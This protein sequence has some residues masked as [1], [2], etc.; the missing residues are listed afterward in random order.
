MSPGAKTKK[1]FEVRREQPINY[2]ERLF[3]RVL[4]D[5]TARDPDHIVALTPKSDTTLPLSFTSITSSQPA[6]AV[7]F[8]SYLLDKH[9]TN[10]S[11]ETNATIAFIS[12]QDFR[13]AVM[14]LSSMKTFHP[15]LLP[16]SRNVLPNTASLIKDTSTKIL[17]CSGARTPL[18]TQAQA[19]QSL[20][21]GL[22]TYELPI[23]EEMT[24]TKT[25]HYPYTA[26][27]F[28]INHQ[29]AIIVYIFGLIGDPKL[30]AYTYAYLSRVDCEMLIPVPEG[31]IVGSL[32]LQREN[33]MN[34]FGG[35]FFHLSGVCIVCHAIFGNVSYVMGPVDRPLTGKIAYEIERSVEIRNILAS[36]EVID[37][38][39]GE[40]GR[41]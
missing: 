24:T 30:I 27:Y 20:I 34:F 36:P 2:G 12:L 32:R 9:L 26:L 15:L 14:E 41:S 35:R 23:L 10:N 39:F 1:P 7:N 17:F 19:F 21:S 25:K 3:P 4:D 11:Y 33:E 28:E 37:G 13:Y 22:Q 40:F 18:E 8:T 6:N 29:K 38:L 16:S 31:R 5:M